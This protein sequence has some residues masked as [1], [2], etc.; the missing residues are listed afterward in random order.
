VNQ[1]ET[2]RQKTDKLRILHVDDDPDIRLLIAGSLQEFGYVVVTAGTVAEALQL[3]R[4]FRFDLFILDVRLPD[5]TGI[6]LC[7][8]L[9]ELQPNVPILYYSAYASE[10]EQKA[11]LSVCGDAYLK[12]PVLAEELE[13]TIARLLNREEQN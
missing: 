3:S 13:Q 6:E 4:E 5:G 8:Q 1:N 10:A 11:A 2:G 12:K 9:R 7:Q